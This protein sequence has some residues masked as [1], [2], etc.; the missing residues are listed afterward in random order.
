MVSSKL[1]P[2]EANKFACGT[3]LTLHVWPLLRLNMW[4]NQSLACFLTTVGFRQRELTIMTYYRFFRLYKIHAYT[5]NALHARSMHMCM[6][7]TFTLA[8]TLDITLGL[9]MYSKRLTGQHPLYLN[10]S[11]KYQTSTC[12]VLFS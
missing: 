12:F 8:N 9:L 3:G 6:Y 2:H 7:I 5:L 4:C 10:S 11:D 1:Y